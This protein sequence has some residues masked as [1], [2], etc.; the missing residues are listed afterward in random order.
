MKISQFKKVSMVKKFQL[1]LGIIYV[2]YYLMKDFQ[3]KIKRG[4]KVKIILSMK[5][6]NKVKKMIKLLC[7]IMIHIKEYF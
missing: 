5:K 3:K 1:N 2:I 4:K 6:I 7:I